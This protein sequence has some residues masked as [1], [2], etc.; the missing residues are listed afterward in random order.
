MY[1]EACPTEEY[2]SLPPLVDVVRV[3]KSFY[4]KMA[5]QQHPK[6][7]TPIV[8]YVFPLLYSMG[9]AVSS[10]G[11]KQAGYII[12]PTLLVMH[13]CIFIYVFI[14]SNNKFYACC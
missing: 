4:Q 1:A 7:I 13:T 10:V 9:V 3:T 11:R 14:C 5:M 6:Y 8:F 12:I 2:T